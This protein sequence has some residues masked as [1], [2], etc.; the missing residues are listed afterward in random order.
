MLRNISI[1]VAILLIL[2]VP[3]FYGNI[4]AQTPSK[5]SN[6]Q[7]LDSNRDLRLTTKV[8]I[9]RGSSDIKDILDLLVQQSK[10]P[11]SV[12]DDHALRKAHLFVSNVP[13]ASVLEALKEVSGLSWRSSGKGYLLYQ[14]EEDRSREKNAIALSE[15]FEQE[16][17]QKRRNAFRDALDNLRKNPTSAQEGLLSMLDP[18]SSEEWDSLL[19]K[20][21]EETPITSATN[22][23]HFYDRLTDAK[24]FRSLS[25]RQQSAVRGALGVL[26]GEGENRL[27]PFADNTFL[28]D[29]SIGFVVTRSGI[30]LGVNRPNTAGN[31][32]PLFVGP[33]GMLTRKG[34]LGVD[35]DTGLEPEVNS[36]IERTKLLSLHGMSPALLNRKIKVPTEAQRQNLAAFLEYLAKETGL[37]IVASD[38]PLGRRYMPPIISTDSAGYPLSAYLDHMAKHYAQT[39]AYRYGML[40]MQPLALGLDLRSEPPPSLVA[41]LLK[42]SNA[43][44]PLTIEDVMDIGKLT[45]KQ[46]L[47]LNIGARGKLVPYV[48]PFTRN[49]K[50]LRLYAE[51]SAEMRAKSESA[52]GLRDEEIDKVVRPF[53]REAIRSGL[54]LDPSIKSKRTAPGIYTKQIRTNDGK[55]VA[56]EMELI[57]NP[58]DKR[59]PLRRW[60]SWAI[61]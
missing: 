33:G 8:T 48:S 60:F 53:F 13:L 37:C 27:Q 41:R 52:E 20:T 21:D 32:E 30:M 15:K 9:K 24:P 19:E 11:L 14:S 55:L 10:V 61:P 44:E 42:K 39:V 4:Q 54:V 6:T 28:E 18:L 31:D 2:S 5:T 51:M 45:S 56:L 25:S 38:L 16:A 57:G 47:T 36:L 26:S 35:S 58:S 22:Q 40:V 34:I 29:S 3:A 23:S 59:F 49:R 1:F 17:N 12:E 43:R 50:P 46:S 7:V